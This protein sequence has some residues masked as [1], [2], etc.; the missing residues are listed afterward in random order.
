[1]PLQYFK[2]NI[3]KLSPWTI[4][5]FASW[6][7]ILLSV[8][9]KFFHSRFLLETHFTKIQNWPPSKYI[10]FA[11]GIASLIN[12]KYQ[13]YPLLLFSCLFFCFWWAYT[14]L[15]MVMNDQ[16]AK[17]GFHMISL[18]L[19]SLGMLYLAYRVNR[20]KGITH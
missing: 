7:L 5:F 6:K 2:E 19:E 12:L 16:F 15:G 3:R 1:M 18:G 17:S 8:M 13:K 4:Y 11:V 14:T 10:M 20:K 9:D